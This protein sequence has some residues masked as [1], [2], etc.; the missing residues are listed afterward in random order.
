MRQIVLW[1]YLFCSVIFY[2]PIPTIAFV[3]VSRNSHQSY[4]TNE[5]F[6]SN[7]LMKARISSC[8]SS[9]KDQREDFRTQAEQLR[10]KA[11]EL[12]MQVSEL[13]GKTEE[14]EKT[15]ATISN[16]SSSTKV[17]SSPWRVPLLDNNE[18]YEYRL[19]VDIGIR[20]R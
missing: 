16:E 6:V 12:R 13:R 11:Q 5:G 20:C 4:W 9:N 19:Y 3:S 18:G 7:R 14:K 10:A 2:R 17:V 8:Y 15:K 1:T